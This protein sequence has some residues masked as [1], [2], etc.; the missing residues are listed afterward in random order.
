M[1]QCQVISGVVPNVSVSCLMSHRH[2]YDLCMSVVS[3]VCVD[4][5]MKHNTVKI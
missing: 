3:N 5:S 1:Y 4:S 2:I